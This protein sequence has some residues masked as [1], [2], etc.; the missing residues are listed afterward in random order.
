MKYSNLMSST[1]FGSAT[2]INIG[3]KIG[4]E[5]E[6][7][8]LILK[9]GTNEIIQ[10]EANCPSAVITKSVKGTSFYSQLEVTGKENI[11]TFLS[12]LNDYLRCSEHAYKLTPHTLRRRRVLLDELLEVCKEWNKITAHFS[13]SSIDVVVIPGESGSDSEDS[14]PSIAE[15]EEDTRKLTVHSW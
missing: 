3:N 5:L 1:I 10:L 6:E 14:D 9:G 11:I 13:D 2:G 12:N 7:E 8:R 15:L 4:I